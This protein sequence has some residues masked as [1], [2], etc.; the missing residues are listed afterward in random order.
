MLDSVTRAGVS[1]AEAAA[2]AASITSASIE[3]PS[4]I[5]RL[6]RAANDEGSSRVKPEV[7]SEV[8]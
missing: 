4:E 7:R 3:R 6:I 8:S 1:S 5:I 2:G